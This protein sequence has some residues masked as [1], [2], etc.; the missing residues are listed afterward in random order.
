MEQPVKQ[1]YQAFTDLNAEG[2]AGCYHDEVVFED[3]AFGVLRGEQAKNMWRMLLASQKGKD[4]K[5]VASNIQENAQ[6]GTAHWEAF[7][8]FSKTG[9]Q[10]HNIIEAE[11]EIQDGLIIKHTDRF[12]LHRWAGQALG[13][14]G[15][16]IGW[17]GFFK[18]KLHAQTNGLLAKFERKV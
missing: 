5:V 8:A 1:F 4:F 13:L 9:R 14:Q 3:P 2:M 7:Y 16:L 18:K 6:K 12:N 15:T 17:T 11:F 10:V